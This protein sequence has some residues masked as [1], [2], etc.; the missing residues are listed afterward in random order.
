MMKVS[1]TLRLSDSDVFEEPWL[2]HGGKEPLRNIKSAGS[3][4]P[5]DIKMRGNYLTRQSYNN[6]ELDGVE[7]FFAPAGV[8][9]S[10]EIGLW[11]EERGKKWISQV[12][13]DET[14]EDLKSWWQRLVRFSQTWSPSKGK[15][16]SGYIDTLG[17]YT[18]GVVLVWDKEVMRTCPIWIKRCSFSDFFC[19]WGLI[20]SGCFIGTLSFYQF[21]K[22]LYLFWP[23]YIFNTIV[24]VSLWDQFLRVEDLPKNLMSIRVDFI[25]RKCKSDNEKPQPSGSWE[26]R[27]LL[28]P[29]N[30]RLCG[31]I[32]ILR[33][34]S[35]MC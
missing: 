20:S 10:L 3:P 24:I 2:F 21:Q 22:T 14:C 27:R 6:T 16:M 18:Q 17:K 23:P 8:W 7:N 30:W 26:S 5:R 31:T 1:Y 15:V 35:L 9:S 12:L 29:L 33:L 13:E 28:V 11:L 34:F 25:E 32:S 19:Y 4:V